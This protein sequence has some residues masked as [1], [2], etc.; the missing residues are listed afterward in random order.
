M[1]SQNIIKLSASLGALAIVMYS[2]ATT[3]QF[4]NDKSGAV[5]WGENCMRCHSNPSPTDFGDEQWKTIVL[6]MKIRANL[7]QDEADKITDFMKSAN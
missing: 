4:A 7:T 1:K 2:C 5:L 3:N 6:H